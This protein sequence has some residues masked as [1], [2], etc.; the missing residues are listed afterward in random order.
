VLR[1]HESTVTSCAFAPDGRQLASAS[2]DGTV[3]LWD[4]AAERE[5]HLCIQHFRDG[6]W[7]VLD[8]SNN[9]VVEASGDAWRW[10]GL[11]VTDP[12]TGAVTRY[13][14]ETLGPLPTPRLPR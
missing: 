5:V 9:R 13:P 3:R 11:M 14:A 12:S 4:L 7:A 10:I 2:G 8:L 1:G 6:S